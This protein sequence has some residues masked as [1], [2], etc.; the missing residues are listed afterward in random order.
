MFYQNKEEK[1]IGY[2]KQVIQ[3]RPKKFQELIM[4]KDPRMRVMH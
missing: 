2:M 3:M 1:D 4:K